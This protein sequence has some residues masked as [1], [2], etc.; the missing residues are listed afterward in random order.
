MEAIAKAHE[1]N[2]Q[3][4]AFLSNLIF[5]AD[6]VPWMSQSGRRNLRKRYQDIIVPNNKRFWGNYTNEKKNRQT[7]R[8][9]YVSGDFRSHSAA[10]LFGP[11]LMG[12]TKRIE[13]ICFS[14][15]SGTA[16]PIG[17]TFRQKA[18]GFHD[19]RGMTDEALDALI[20][21]EKID[22]LVDLSGH[23]SENRMQLFSRKPAPVQLTAWGFP[24]GTGLDAM[25]WIF[26]GPER[27]GANHERSYQEKPWRLVAGVP[28]VPPREIAP[29]VSPSPFLT[30]GDVTFG[31]L[32]GMRKLNPIT[33]HLFARVLNA[34]PNSRIL[35]KNQNFSQPSPRK[36]VTDYLGE[37]GVVIERIG[38]LG[39]TTREEHLAAFANVDICLE[40]IP[41][42]GGMTLIEGLWQGVPTVALEGPSVPERGNCE[43]LD[44]CGLS[45]FVAKTKDEYV[46][47]A[48]TK[49]SPTHL[50]ALATLRNDMRAMIDAAPAANIEKY[51]RE[52]EDAYFAMFD[53]W[54]ML[55]GRPGGEA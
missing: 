42:G 27:P 28:I 49:T 6:H 30:V 25:D 51:V 8:V 3:E 21:K 54:A 13:W 34:V 50:P 24:T 33:L 55:D 4:P 53:V 45:S 41:A 18:N 46:E 19:V 22:V 38:F 12:H 35:F 52:V 14:G 11:V 16:N 20:R 5:G 32:N 43:I 36:M 40:P 9:G 47:I 31:C 10:A 1:M 15:A 17:E 26:D 37:K 2:P 39:A 44:Q 7:L 29:A 48:K 23:S